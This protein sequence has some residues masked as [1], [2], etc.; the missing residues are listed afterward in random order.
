MR[1]TRWLITMT[2]FHLWQVLLLGPESD[3]REWMNML[4]A[5]YE[6]SHLKR[7]IALWRARQG[8]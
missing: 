1:A 6:N 3:R 5:C 8:K 7:E 2:L 4:V